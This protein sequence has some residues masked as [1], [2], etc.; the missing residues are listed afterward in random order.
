MY[1]GGGS[2]N[3]R[4]VIGNPAGASFDV[5]A[6]ATEATGFSAF[7]FFKYGSSTEFSLGRS[8]SNEFVSALIIPL[9]Y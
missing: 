9:L 2:G 4:F 5:G 7:N 1:S 6:G 3:A 8:M